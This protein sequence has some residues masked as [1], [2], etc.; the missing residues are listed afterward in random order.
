MTALVFVCMVLAAYRAT[1]FVTDDSLIDR[2]RH[3]WFLRFPPD[4]EY[5][6]WRFEEGRWVNHATPVRLP[7]KLG[8]LIQCPLCTGWWA[9]GVVLACFAAF[10]FV[11]WRWRSIALWPAVAGGQG[12]LNLVDSKLS[13]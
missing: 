10:G 11:D 4:D 8:Q 6:R 1:R 3:R 12:L 13:D 9:S 2:L 7:H 5:G